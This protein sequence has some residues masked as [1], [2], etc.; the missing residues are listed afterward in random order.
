[1]IGRTL[2]HYRI[3]RQLGSGGMGEVYLAEDTALRR[4]IALKVLPARM[5]VVPDRMR[6]FVQEA[7][8]TSALNH[9]NIATIHELG[10]ADDIHFIVMEYVEGETLK[11]RLTRG[12]LETSEIIGIARQIADALDVAHSRGIVHRDIK[13]SN[14]MI[15]TRGHVKVLDFGLAKRLAFEQP[16]DF[17][18]TR[19]ATQ[20][21]VVMGTVPY[22]SPEQTLGERVDQRSDFFSLGVVLYEMATG[23][24][25]F[26]GS[27]SY[28]LINRI[29]HHDPQPIRSIN[30]RISPGLERLVT[31]CL[32]KR[33]ENRFETAGELARDL[34]MVE[35][36]SGGHPLECN[37]AFKNNLPQ[38]LTRFIGRQREIDEIRHALSHTRLVTLSG[39]P[40]IGKT[41]L[42]LQVAAES[43][44]Q[45][46]D[47]VWFVELASVSDPDLVPQTVASILGVREER[48]RS[49]TATVMDH[50]K[51]R[52]LLLV[53]DNCEH[54]IGACAQL[55]DVLLRSSPTLR[56]LTT[57]KESL[58]IAGE[59][60]LRIPP[61]TIPDLQRPSEI[62]SLNRHESVQLFVDRARSV[63][64]TFAITNSTAV[65]L[66]NL[67]VR[68]EGIPLA[69]ELAASRVKV[70]SI[71]QISARLDDRLNLLTG[72]SRTALAR[73][74]TLL[75]AID[76]SYNLLTEA[77][78][79]LFRRL[80]VFSGEWTLEAAEVVCVGDGVVKKSV[81]E[82]LSGL[83]DK[84]LVLADERE[85]QERYR[86]MV[87]LLEYAQQR[88]M[89]TDEAAT[90]LRRHAEFFIAL[91]LESESKL[92]GAEQKVWLERLNADYDNIR[93][94]L[95]WASKNNT[96][97]GLRLAGALG[98][99]WYL[100]GYWNEGRRWLAEMLQAPGALTPPPERIRALNAAARIAENQGEH[101]A[102]RTFS[103]EAL[104]LSRESGDQREA[105]VALNCLAIL[106]AND[107]DF[108]EARSLLE[109]SL[110]IRRQLGDQGVV[111]ITLNNLG[112]LALRQGELV[113]AGAV[114][115]ESL[116]I[117]RQAGDKHGIA[118]GLL[119]RG[120]VARRMGDDIARSL[121]ER[122]LVLARDMGDK[123]LLPAALNSLGELFG[124]QGDDVA[125]V[126]LQTESLDASRE[127][128]D[129][130][131]SACA[132]LSLGVLAQHRGDYRAARSLL[133]E[134]L[135]IRRDLGEKPEIAE[136]LT[137]MGRVSA[138]ER[139]YAEAASLYEESLA[140]G[141]RT[142]AQDRIAHSL[143][144]LADVA[145]LA[146]DHA[147]ALSL[148]KRSLTILQKLGEKPEFLRP[149]E[150]L[151]AVV[152]AR[153]QHLRSV[154]LW[155]AAQALRDILSIPR[156][157]DDTDEYNRHLHAARV[158]LGEERFAAAWAQGQAMGTDVAIAD[159]LQGE[160]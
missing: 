142:G 85:G 26:S 111:A 113:A 28:E 94:V 74:Q 47:G 54:L 70:L 136:V 147:A 159:A 121:I 145:C 92:L 23:R 93:A 76:W 86:F 131:T 84:S 59:T 153:G 81:L 65:P 151:A 96:A 52:R 66:A 160:E 36:R 157:F 30:P 124:R 60:I 43:L 73:H 146:G 78:R 112:V 32:E 45:Y 69:I 115:E 106:A 140:L 105:G 132:L 135:A 22:M 18:S 9:P 87:T 58:A 149:L 51:E 25:P 35:T 139:D 116:A 137:C 123:T 56:I 98:R 48:G 6:R 119:N 155:G 156:P 99:F 19:E 11:A 42:A 101:P 12:S 21:G 89:Q 8:A 77:E 158:A 120:E 63:K 133:E 29:V 27:T 24:L 104:T 125:A 44:R 7:R 46:A 100:Q 4:Q 68:L 50:L 95:D 16:V 110:T 122:A 138:R 38:Q 79:L 49:I 40:G 37:E 97:M 127:L 80:S 57:S 109:E 13:P 134:S 10:E 55:A 114:F 61:L 17:D 152:M 31:R 150:N 71:E 128:G 20:S 67:C 82:L 117:S 2:A 64:S 130:R 103:M 148:Y 107:D 33:P 83:V 14:I 72:G 39:P 118:M 75:A 88:L 126:A 90:V 154:R 53:L 62:T 108:T 102:A 41:R 129:K 91:A 5:S 1:V 141:E 143:N 15:T 34:R 3:V 144:G